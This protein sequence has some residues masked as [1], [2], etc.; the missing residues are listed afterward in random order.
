MKRM[1]T[2]AASSAAVLLVALLVT[3]MQVDRTTKMSNGTTGSVLV[4]DDA[5]FIGASK[6]KTCHRKP[7][8][9]EQFGK[10]EESGHASAYATLGTDKAKALAA[11]K[12]ID[13]PQTADECLSCHITAHGVAPERLGEKYSVDEGVTCEACHGPGGNYYKKKTM[14]SIMTGEIEGASVGL[15]MPNEETCVACHNE[16][17]PTFEGFDFDEYFKKIAHPIPDE[18]KAQY[19]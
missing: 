14:E 8:A 3:A 18:T 19:Q 13:N 7:E 17:S 6:C 4:A 16:K 11:E 10:W 15:V 1:I 9:G 12:G 5:E 2:L